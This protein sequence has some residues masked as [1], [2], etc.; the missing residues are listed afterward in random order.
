MNAQ[1]LST[2]REQAQDL[3][4]KSGFVLSA[5]E[6]AELSINDFGLGDFAA[7]GFAF[8]D[9]LRSE[10][11]RITVFVLLPRQSLPQ[12]KHPPYDSEIGKEETLRA[13][14]G[15]TNIYIDGDVNNPDLII[16]AGKE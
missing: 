11:L 13:L 15:Q 7:E 3:I 1:Q 14:Y 8:V 2:V 16:P 9:I 5:E 4:R 10:R 12:H 6:Q